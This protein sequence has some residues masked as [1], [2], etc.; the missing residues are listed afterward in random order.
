MSIFG[1]SLPPGCH[2]L[3][4]DETGAIDL[5][6]EGM[7]EQVGIYWT[8]DD[9]ILIVSRPGRINETILGKY[10]FVWSDRMNDEQNIAAATEFAATELRK[11]LT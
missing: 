1:W 8:E 3:P 4:Y 5:K 11:L 6:F 7:P 10:T 2:S 9:E